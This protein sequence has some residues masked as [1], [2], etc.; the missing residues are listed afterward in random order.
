[1][2]RFLHT[3]DWQLGMKGVK[4]GKDAAEFVRGT[5]IETCR[6]LLA[7]AGKEKV[8]FVLIVGDLFENNA[9]SRDVVEQALTLFDKVQIPIYILPG[10]HDPFEPDSVYIQ[11]V[12]L[13]APDNVKVLTERK[14][15]KLDELDTI[16]YPCPITQKRSRLD[17]TDWIPKEKENIEEI[18]IGI[19]H[20][21]LDIG[22][23]AEPNFPINPDRVEESSLDYLALGDW[24]SLF[25]HRDRA[26]AQ[27]TIY[28]GTPE[29]TNFDEIDPGHVVS[30]EINK[31]EEPKIKLENCGQLRWMKWEDEHIESRQDLEA[32]AQKVRNLEKR[33]RTL[34]KLILKGVVDTEV[35]NMIEELKSSAKDL[36]YIEVDTSGLHLEPS[37]KSMLGVVPEGPLMK[38][39][40]SL[41]ALLSREPLFSRRVEVPPEELKRRL[42]EIKELKINDLDPNV[43]QKAFSLLYQ[44][45]KEVK[46]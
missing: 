31:G 22:L 34:L 38:V 40:E 36:R 46:E 42:E 30:V 1:M 11:R 8:D 39:A 12:W 16:L 41:E 19:A 13:T 45:S 2:V 29:A 3:A 18:H 21:T 5:R 17:P 28:P 35:Y 26:G 7:K 32:L 20:G 23:T 43:A 24:H 10:N 37:A 4:L 6:R 14:P 33:D 25:I 15:M 9:V 44:F 27:R